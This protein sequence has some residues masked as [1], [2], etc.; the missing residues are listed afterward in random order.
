MFV[1]WFC[2]LFD[3]KKVQPP[4]LLFRGLYKDFDYVFGWVLGHGGVFVTGSAQVG[5]MGGRVFV[6]FGEK[7]RGVF[8]SS[9]LDVIL[10]MVGVWCARRGVGC[11]W[12]G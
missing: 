12:K 10:I 8:V 9:R 7:G 2:G 5:K 1:F 11:L 4:F 6:R 3:G